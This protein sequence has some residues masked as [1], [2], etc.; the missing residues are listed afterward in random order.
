MLLFGLATAI[1]IALHIWNRKRTTNVRWAASR[2]LEEAIRESSRRMR[3]ER[4]LLLVT[5]CAIVAILAIALARPIL[6]GTAVAPTTQHVVLILDASLSMQADTGLGT[7][8]AVAKQ[9]LRQ[10]VE[11]EIDG[12][13]FSLCVIGSPCDILMWD[14]T[15]RL[16]V[17]DELQSTNVQDGVG[18]AKEAIDLV[19]LQLSSSRLDSDLSTRVVIASDFCENSWSDVSDG[20]LAERTGEAYEL[21]DVG[22]DSTANTAI[23]SATLA[24]GYAVTGNLVTILAELRNNSDRDVESQLSIEPAVETVGATSIRIPAHDTVQVPITTTIRQSGFHQVELRC[25]DD[26]LSADNVFRMVV[27]VKAQLH[28]LCVESESGAADYMDAALAVA[29]NAIGITRE[30]AA[31]LPATLDFDAVVLCDATAMQ[32]IDYGRLEDYVLEGGILIVGAGPAT[33]QI[34]ETSRNAAVLFNAL[35]DEAPAGE[36]RIDDT[37]LTHPALAPFRTQPQSGLSGSVA[38]KYRTLAPNDG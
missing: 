5:R 2:F 27:P 3:L 6:S 28:V 24:E 33:R 29:D 34:P 15:N 31:R 36:Y 22:T 26:I 13:H 10:V 30:P 9:R 8:F 4:A 14:R 16:T 21:I 20:A 11:Q 35:G 17:L 25:S 12:T 37:R 1:P 18:H 32:E 19:R 23:V 38:W 7:R